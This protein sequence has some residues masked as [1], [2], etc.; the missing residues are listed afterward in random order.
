MNLAT[1]EFLAKVNKKPLI[2]SKIPY[3]TH[4]WGASNI[5]PKGLQ[6]M[7]SIMEEASSIAKAIETAWNRAGQ[8]TEFSVKVLELPQTSFFGLKT[9][10]SAKVAF[11]FNEATVTVKPKE[12]TSQ[13]RHSQQRPVTLRQTGN[14]PESDYAKT[15]SDRQ[16]QRRSDY[17][18]SSDRSD[19]AKTSTDRHDERK[20]RGTQEKRSSEQRPDREQRRPSFTKSESHQERTERT[21]SPN[22]QD[23][24]SRRYDD[25][26]PRHD[27][28]RS[29]RSYNAEPRESWTPE[30]AEVALEWIKET[31][32]LMGK[33]DISVN[34]HISHNYLKINLSIPV[35]D[36]ARQ[37]ETQL[38]SWG[39]LAMEAV[40]EKMGKP[41]RSL[42]IVLESPRK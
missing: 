3:R 24:R 18:G 11:F 41:L 12:Q 8:P 30:M 20:D 10:K 16:D 21:E 2:N 26:R 39:M 15:T 25:R 6:N 42:R 32:V 22:R 4:T 1:A 23:N 31:L 17:R 19:Y 29:E 38:K 28:E 14:K 7:K 27:G 35:L 5:Y 13:Q 33:S 37:E 40:R 34:H 36:D 9:S